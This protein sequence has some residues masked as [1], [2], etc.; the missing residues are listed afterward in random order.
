MKLFLI[1]S[2]MIVLLSGLSSFAELTSDEAYDKVAAYAAQ[3][4]EGFPVFLEMSYVREG[5]EPVISKGRIQAGGDNFK[6]G[7]IKGLLLEEETR[8]VHQYTQSWTSMD[9]AIQSFNAGNV[10]VS[11]EALMA[12]MHISEEVGQGHP[13]NNVIRTRQVE[14][15]HFRPAFI[16]SNFFDAMAFI[17]RYHT[18][19]TGSA[20]PENYSHEIEI[21]DESIVFTMKT[22]IEQFLPEQRFYHFTES[23][24]TIQDDGLKITRIEK[25]FSAE[26][27]RRVD[28]WMKFKGE[29][30]SVLGYDIIEQLLTSYPTPDITLTDFIRFHLHQIVLKAEGENDRFSFDDARARHFIEKF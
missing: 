3:F 19:T 29:S 21:E 4:A 27:A 12:D 25:G 5:K 26:G 23:H 10:T 2:L 7:F 6:A 30:D 11:K 20:T 13:L 16:P 14:N 28:S 8:F 9:D 18:G 1:A 24:F 15:T 22:L 17:H